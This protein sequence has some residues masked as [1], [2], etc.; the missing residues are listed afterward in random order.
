MYIFCSKFRLIKLVHLSC[1]CDLFKIF[2]I[3]VVDVWAVGCIMAELLTGETLFP[4]E[5]GIFC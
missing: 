2:F 3:F 4:G 5:H 1:D